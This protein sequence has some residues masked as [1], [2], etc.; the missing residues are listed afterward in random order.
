[1]R[2]EGEHDAGASKPAGNRLGALEHCDMAAVDAVKIADGDDCA[3]EAWRRGLGIDGD[4]EA[5]RERR[6][7]ESAIGTGKGDARRRT[8]ATLP[9][10][11]AQVKRGEQSARNKPPQCSQNLSLFFSPGIARADRIPAL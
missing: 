6:S 2:L 3:L 10:A 9:R 11:A 4:D 7:E 8:G 1:M 5:R